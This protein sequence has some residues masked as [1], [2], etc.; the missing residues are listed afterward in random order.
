MYFWS[1][2]W[3]L[4][5]TSVSITCTEVSTTQNSTKSSQTDNHVGSS[6]FSDSSSTSI[7]RVLM[8][9]H[10]HSAPLMCPQKAWPIVGYNLPSGFCGWSPKINMPGLD[11]NWMN[12]ASVWVQAVRFLL[13]W[14]LHSCCAVPY[15]YSVLLQPAFPAGQD[16]GVFLPPQ[17]TVTCVY[18]YY[19]HYLIVHA[20]C[21]HK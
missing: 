18:I 21:L 4:G 17:V 19:W 5:S 11:C 10:A 3:G 20:S 1:H 2:V 6:N 16:M 8:S 14:S 12:Q 9:V 15:P 7:N 13:A